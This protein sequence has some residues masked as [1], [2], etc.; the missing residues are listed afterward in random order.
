MLKQERRIGVGELLGD[1]WETEPR[2]LR[3]A[4]RINNILECPETEWIVCLDFEERK[5]RSR[6]YMVTRLCSVCYIKQLVENW[7]NVSNVI[8]S[9]LGLQFPILRF[10]CFKK[11]RNQIDMCVQTIVKREICKWIFSIVEGRWGSKYF[12]ECQMLIGQAYFYHEVP[13]MM[14]II[15]HVFLW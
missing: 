4:S 5:R 7:K 10:R 15:H 11:Q 12:T 9:R 1:G 8:I 3:K 13:G 14:L 2:L 6:I